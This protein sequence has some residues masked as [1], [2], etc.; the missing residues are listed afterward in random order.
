MNN[1]ICAIILAV[2]SGPA[3]LLSDTIENAREPWPDLSD[4]KALAKVLEKA[5]PA[6]KLPISTKDSESLVYLPDRQTLYTGWSKKMHPN[7]K[8][9]DL[10]HYKE[11][12]RHGPWSRWYDNGQRQY[13]FMMKGGKM[14]EGTGWKPTGEPSPTKIANGNGL[15]VGYHTNGRKRFEGRRVNGDLKGIVSLWYGN[16]APY[17]QRNYKHGKANG[18]AREWISSTN[19]AIVTARVERI[20]ANPGNLRKLKG[21]YKNGVRDGE[22]LEFDGQGNPAFRITYKAGATVSRTSAYGD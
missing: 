9:D 17:W 13:E 22:W 19:P 20:P 11:G 12:K 6:E 21:S 7:G 16:G 1:R 15:C 18:P 5:M 4:S 2:V 8:I 14:M 3:L 10:V